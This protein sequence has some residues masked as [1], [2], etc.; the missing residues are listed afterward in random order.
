MEIFGY[1]NLEVQLLILCPFKLFHSS[2]D[3]IKELL[4]LKHIGHDKVEE[5]PK[6]LQVVAERSASEQ[7]LECGVEIAKRGK[8]LGLGVFDFMGFIDD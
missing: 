6:L 1:L 7:Q 3:L 8:A 5:S 2:F 4:I